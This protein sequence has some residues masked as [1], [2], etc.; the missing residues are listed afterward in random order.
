MNVDNPIICVTGNEPMPVFAK[1]ERVA[2]RTVLIGGLSHRM[3]SVV[4]S[5]EL[6]SK[7]SDDIPDPD[8][9]WLG[10]D[11]VDESDE[12]GPVSD[13]KQDHGER[14][15]YKLKDQPFYMRGRNGKMRGY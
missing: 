12:Y 3:L 14:T 15:N 8:L 7:L 1:E 11:P 2:P 6:I 9:D 13:C 10:A 5:T 4:L